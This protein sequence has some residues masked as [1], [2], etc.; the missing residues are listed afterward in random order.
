[1]RRFAILFGL[2]LVGTSASAEVVTSSDAGFVSRLAVDVSV[3]PE[4][5]WK[6]LIAPATWWS[7]E[8][9]YSGD[10]ANLYLDAQATGCFCELLPL[11]KD[12]AEGTRRGSVEHLHVVYADPGKVLRLTGGL[13][14]LQSEAVGGSL[15]ITLKP[16]DGGTRIQWFY[17]VGGYARFKFP[18]MAVVVDKV[19]AQ[20]V[21]RLGEKLGTSAQVSLL[22]ADAKP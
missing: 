18:D 12:A 3:P 21:A 14:P 20:Q 6:T 1:M 10:A 4:E 2:A 17:V 19:L 13:G 8:H 7:S 5:A 16:V 15:T 22:P 9:T 11:P